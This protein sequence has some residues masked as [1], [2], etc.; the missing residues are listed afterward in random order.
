MPHW[1]GDVSPR[2]RQVAAIKKGNQS[3]DS[4]IT[5]NVHNGTHI[6][7]PLHFLNK[8]GT[9]DKV[10]L[11]ALTGP[12]FVAYLPKAKQI[13]AKDLES[14]KLPPKTGRLLLKTSN[15]K[16]WEKRVPSFQKNY[17]GLTSDGASWVAKRG[18]ELVG[19]DYLSIARFKEVVDVHQILLKKKVVILEGLDLS[20]VRPGAYQLV[21]LP[22]KVIGIEAA[23][24]RAILIK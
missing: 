6:D 20:G 19:I 17:V 2:I 7:A 8:G 18:L 11:E 22:L 1:P 13:S 12:A 5:M 4:E 15:S 23:P 21:C 9:I 14:L 3:N 24:A 10:P 16:F